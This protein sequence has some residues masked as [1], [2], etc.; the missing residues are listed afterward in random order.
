[1]SFAYVSVN[2]WWWYG[3]NLW[4]TFLGHPVN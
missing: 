4:L 3:Q 1:M 2:I